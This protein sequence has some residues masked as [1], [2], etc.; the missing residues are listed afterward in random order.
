M[1]TF[2]KGEQEDVRHVSERYIAKSDPYI[3]KEEVQKNL[4]NIK[5]L[6]DLALFS[7]IQSMRENPDKCSSLVYSD[8]PQSI[9]YSNY[10]YISSG[11]KQQQQSQSDDYFSI[12]DCKAEIIDQ[13]KEFYIFLVDRIVCEVVNGCVTNLLRTTSVPALPLEEGG[14]DDD[15]QN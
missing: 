12:E 5:P 3:V 4:S 7:V 13:A 1:K 14:A 15:K 9:R 11:L 6:L 10:R 2:R 8:N